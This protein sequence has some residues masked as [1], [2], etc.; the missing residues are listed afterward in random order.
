[1]RLTVFAALF[2]LAGHA[3]RP[4]AALAGKTSDLITTGTAPEVSSS[5]PM[6]MKSNS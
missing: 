2:A 4:I 3:V 1:L 5:A 6:S